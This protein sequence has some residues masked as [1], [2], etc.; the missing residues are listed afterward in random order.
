MLRE[1][2]GDIF[3]TRHAKN[4]FI[5]RW[6]QLNRERNYVN[7][8]KKMINMITRSR[9]IKSI[10]KPNGEVY[11]YRESNGCIF[12]CAREFSNSYWKK[13]KVT[14]VTVELEP[15]YI[16]NKYEAG[17]DIELLDLNEY[18]KLKVKEKILCI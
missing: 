8:Y 9:L 11:E 13:D 2:Y 14:V 10:S 5:Q 6:I 15:W 17:V 1:F 4:R 12:V 7:V 16:Q 18:S 3:I